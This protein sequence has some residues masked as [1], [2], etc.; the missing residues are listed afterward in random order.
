[1]GV[2]PSEVISVKRLYRRTSFSGSE[3]LQVELTSAG[4]EHRSQHRSRLDGLQDV[5]RPRS[6][7]VEQCAL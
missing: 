7:P 3:A 1:M 2:P 5:F 6:V 4:P